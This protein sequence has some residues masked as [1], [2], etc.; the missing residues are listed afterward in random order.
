MPKKNF[1][2][3]ISIFVLVGLVVFFV[4]RTKSPD[5]SLKFPIQDQNVQAYILPISQ[6]NYLPVRNFNILDPETNAKAAGI[7]DVRSER[8][9]YTKNIDK[10]LPIASITKL[11]TAIVIIENLSLNDPFTVEA[12][13]VNVD[14]HGADFQK[15]ETIRGADLLK[16]ML[17]KSSNDA[18]LTFASSAQSK[19]IN[20][21][22]KM[23]D[24]AK[25]IGMLDTKFNDPAGLEDSDSFST[26]SD[27]VKLVRYVSKYPIIWD[28]LLTKSADVSSADGRMNHHLISTNRLLGEISNIVGGK[29]GFTDGALET[30]VLEISLNNGRDQMISIILGSNDRFGETKKLINWAQTAYRW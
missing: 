16:I 29:T 2:L 6:S 9:L 7:F 5:S 11:M 4:F 18:A 12:E 14:G 10:K 8:F 17:I 3:T 1:F 22:A 15:G 21:V 26:V 19:N 20:L 27:L 24:K 30:M 13:D 23:N 25:L 28:I